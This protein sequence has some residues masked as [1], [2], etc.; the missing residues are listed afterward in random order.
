M[1]A[2]QLL[3]IN[4]CLNTGSFLPSCYTAPSFEKISNFKG[5][6]QF[7]CFFTVPILYFANMIRMLVYHVVGCVVCIFNV[8]DCAHTDGSFPVG[9]PFSD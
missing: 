9:E 8:L 2:A 4:Y 1:I 5:H 6:N 7:V 3:F